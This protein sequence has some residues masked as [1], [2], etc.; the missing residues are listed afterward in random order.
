MH[1][2]FMK[3]YEESF[4]SQLV[5]RKCQILY[6]S[7]Q[8]YL[9][10]WISYCRWDQ[11]IGPVNKNVLIFFFCLKK[12]NGFTDLEETTA[13]NRGKIILLRFL[14]KLLTPQLGSL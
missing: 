2:I 1:E 8:K 14:Q 9:F 6:S 12:F 3:L 7:L 4:V 5:K 13:H 11:K 10:Q